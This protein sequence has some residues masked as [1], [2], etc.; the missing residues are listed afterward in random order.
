MTETE[1]KQS[2]ACIVDFDNTCHTRQRSANADFSYPESC[3]DIMP[4]LI[5][6]HG[7]RISSASYNRFSRHQ[8]WRRR[9]CVLN[10]YVRTGPFPIGL[11]ILVT[12][13][14]SCEPSSHRRCRLIA[15]TS[16]GRFGLRYGF[17]FASI[18]SAVGLVVVLRI[19]MEN[20]ITG[21]QWTLENLIAS[22]Q[23]L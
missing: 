16:H 10:S 3:L 11:A 15:S 19:R 4:V 9:S 21:H 5:S 17:A 13:R 8:T 23:A 20:T 18:L 12:N 6:W 2:S 1:Q 7:Q 22:L 14:K